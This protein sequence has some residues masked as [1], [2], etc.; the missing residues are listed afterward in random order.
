MA[1]LNRSF[2]RGIAI[3]CTHGDFANPALLAAVLNF[4]SI[5]KPHTRI[6]LGDYLDLA[7]F[8]GGAKGS[9]DEVRPLKDDIRGGFN[10]LEEYRPTHLINGNHDQRAAELADHHNQIIA[11]AGQK[12]VGE[13]DDLVKRLRCQ[14]L[15]EYDI[16]SSWIEIGGVKWLHGFVWNEMF[17]RDHAEMM[18]DCVIAHGHK[19][20]EATGRRID[21]PV[22]HCVGTLAAVPAMK[23]ANRRRAT[24]AWS[25]GFVWFEYTDTECHRWLHEFHGNPSNLPR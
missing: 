3:G 19:T 22:C 21:H 12:I 24:L 23:Y 1:N 10:F 20:G 9:K 6:H 8:R 11:A 14:H 5:Y 15:A 18:G 4:C 25:A 13:I 7:A 2:K 17:I 16:N